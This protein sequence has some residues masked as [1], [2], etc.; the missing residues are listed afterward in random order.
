VLM[1]NGTVFATGYTGTALYAE[2]G[3][4]TAGPTFPT[5]TDGQVGAT[6]AP[7]ALLTNGNV[8]IATSPGVDGV[9]VHYFEFNGTTLTEMPRTPNAAN[10]AANECRFLELPSGQIL[11]TDGST[12]VEIYTPSG[13]PNP[14]W[15]PKIES[16]SSELKQGT[17]YVV[18]GTQFNGLSQGASFGDDAQM[19]TNYP[20]VRLTMTATGDVYY[21]K[22][23]DHSSMGV[24]TGSALVSTTFD[25][26]AYA[27]EVGP[28]EL[29][30]VANGI[31]SASV[32]VCVPQTEAQACA[33]QCSGTAPDDCGGRLQ[34][35]TLVGARCCTHLGGA[36][37]GGR[38]E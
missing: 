1:T 19:A 33:Y 13:A 17:S 16:V 28:A 27:E 36:W 2:D 26:P 34:C 31:A 35:L 7:A 23:H 14:A 21:F 38:C 29:Q 3:F 20:L 32:P 24:A 8:L 18:S 6:D 37:S 4:W 5:T 30:V 9:G 15:A 10:V 11:A 25:V 22:T 12:E